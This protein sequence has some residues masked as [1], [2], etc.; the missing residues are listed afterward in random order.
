MFIGFLFTI[1][2]ST[3]KV[4]QFWKIADSWN[5]I[6]ESCIL[7]PFHICSFLCPYGSRMYVLNDKL[8]IQKCFEE[9]C[10]LLI[11]ILNRNSAKFTSTM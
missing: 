8:Y 10:L 5:P 7:L 1:N 9:H 6:V 11:H 2:V 3:W 4:E